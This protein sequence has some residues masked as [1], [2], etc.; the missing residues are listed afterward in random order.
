[1][2]VSL[3]DTSGAQIEK[4]KDKTFVH[5]PQMLN[6]ILVNIFVF[7]LVLCPS[8]VTIVYHCV[9][10]VLSLCCDIRKYIHHILSPLAVLTVMMQ[11]YERMCD[12]GEND[13]ELMSEIFWFLSLALTFSG[14][15]RCL[16]EA[17][18][19]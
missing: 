4:E 17:R 1:M 10:V 2:P 8:I 11:L 12:E 5:S 6:T 19:K 7:Y 3:I 14:C 15:H 9:T 18:R 13:V 16:S